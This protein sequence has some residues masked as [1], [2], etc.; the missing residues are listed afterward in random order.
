MAPQGSIKTT[1]TYRLS[2]T[3]ESAPTADSAPL[4][5]QVWG[6]PCDQKGYLKLVAQGYAT[7][8]W[9]SSILS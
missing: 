3:A 5:S 4:L 9:P 8:P 7:N 1:N 2:P 6:L